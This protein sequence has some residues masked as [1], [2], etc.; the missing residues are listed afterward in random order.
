M[1]NCLYCCEIEPDL[2]PDGTLSEY[3]GDECRRKALKTGFLKPCEQCKEFPCAKYSRFCGWSECRNIPTGIKCKKKKVRDI[4]SLWCSKKCRDDT[5]NWKM[6]IKSDE[7]CLECRQEYPLN[8]KDFCKR[9]CEEYAQNNGRKFKDISNQFSSSWKHKNK[10]IPNVYAVY[11]IFPNHDLVT[12]YNDYRNYVENRRGFGYKGRPFPKGDEN[13]TMTRG[14]EQRRFHGTRMKC[15][16]G[17]KTDT[18]CSNPECS[19]CGIIINGFKLSYEGPRSFPWQK[20]GEGIYFSGTS[21]KSDYFSKD[22]KTHNSKKY[23]AM[24]LNKVVVGRAFEMLEENKDMEGSPANYDS[25]VGEPGEKLNHDELIV[26]KE[27][28]CLPRYLII[29]EK[30]G[31]SRRNI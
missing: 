21:S 30:S 8:G 31:E 9:E 2:D 17:I 28:A 15:F 1:V 20:F 16:L 7:L 24:L 26:Y 14:N 23:K 5:P 12:K 13:R 25:V 29:Y 22:T 4:G 19:I 10:P 27:C 6:M 18:L 11:K 3:C